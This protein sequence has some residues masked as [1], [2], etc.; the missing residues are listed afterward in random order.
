MNYEAESLDRWA[1]GEASAMLE[2]EYWR[3]VQALRRFSEREAKQRPAPHAP[4][5]LEIAARLA[6]EELSN[7]PAPS[8][9]D[10]LHALDRT[11]ASWQ[12][13]DAPYQRLQ[14]R[15]LVYTLGELSL[16]HQLLRGGD[17]RE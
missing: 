16:L 14:T 17:E 15:R 10:T 13:E 4:N 6:V 8:L 7:G 9:S 5:A 3:V 1:E 12:A 11:F 2:V